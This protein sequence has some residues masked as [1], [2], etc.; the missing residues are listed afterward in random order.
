MKTLLTTILWCAVG[1]PVAWAHSAHTQVTEVE[2]SPVSGRFEVAMKLDAVALEDSVSIHTGQRFRLESSANVD[3]VLEAWIPKRFQVQVKSRRPTAGATIRW[4]GH[5]L[6]LHTVWLYFEY[7]PAAAAQSGSSRKATTP[8]PEPDGG[9][10]DLDVVTVKN[11]C[12]LDVRPDTIHFIKLR[13]GQSVRQGHCS[14]R[15]PCTDFTR[16]RHARGM[17]HSR[18][19]THALRSTRS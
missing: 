9:M 12:L 14:A 19:S 8:L 15:K 10:I 17:K 1:A 6:N 11:N 18:P 16:R 2:Y 13:Q 3:T 5:E 7:I 4:V